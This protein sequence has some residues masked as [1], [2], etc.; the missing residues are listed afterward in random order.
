MN[1]ESIDEKDSEN[2]LVH[3]NQKNSEG[4]EDTPIFGNELKKN[5][6]DLN[7]EVDIHNLTDQI[8]SNERVEEDFT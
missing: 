1:E 7:V 4:I 2:E 8:S 5:I 6:N 3:Q